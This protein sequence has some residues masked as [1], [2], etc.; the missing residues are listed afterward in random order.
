MQHFIVKL[1]LCD[2][3][4]CF[5]TLLINKMA[6][7]I[8]ENILKRTMK[9]KCFKTTKY[10]NWPQPRVEFSSIF[11]G[12]G[13]QRFV[14][15]FGFCH[16]N[17]DFW[18]ILTSPSGERKFE[19]CGKTSFCV[20][21]PF[22]RCAGIR[23]STS[24]PLRMVKPT[25]LRGCTP[26]ILAEYAYINQLQRTLTFYFKATSL[27]QDFKKGA[28]WRHGRSS[29]KTRLIIIVS[30]HHV[31]NLQIKRSNSEEPFSQCI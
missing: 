20:S 14:S 17:P 10:K 21:S 8:S 23:W 16:F 18:K 6:F 26:N 22:D 5:F 11:N 3:S 1:K 29:S 19:S 24:S 4:P 15:A 9:Q 28:L 12:G 13:V 27:K 2:C 7:N 30:R 31:K 25:E